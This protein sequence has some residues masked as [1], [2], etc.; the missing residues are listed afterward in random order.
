V[1]RFPRVPVLV[2]ALA[3]LAS[4]SWAQPRR[5]SPGKLSN[6]HKQLE[7]VENC[8]KCHELGKGVSDELCLDCHTAIK[9]RMENKRGL[10]ASEEHRGKSCQK[11]HPEHN[12]REFKL[13]YW[14]EGEKKFD[15][16]QAGYSL[17][18]KHLGH[19]CGDC[20]KP[21]F[22]RDEAVRKD[23]RINLD[24]TRLG[25]STA[26]VACHI[27]EH[28][29][30]LPDDCLKCHTY[31]GWTPARGFTHDSTPYPL[32]GKHKDI[33][34]TKCHPWRDARQTAIADA[35]QKPENRGKQAVYRLTG[36]YPNCT[37]CH[38]DPHRGKH[39]Q[40]CS[41]CHQISGWADLVGGKPYDH[42]LSGYP[43]RG[44]HAGVQ[45]VKCHTSGR[46]TDPLKF[47]HCTDCH[48]DEHRGQFAGRPGGIACE[49]CHTVAGFV[50]SRFTIEQHAATKYPLEGS[51]LAVP[52]NLCH[53]QVA[54]K[55]GTTYAQFTF[56]QR[57]CQ[58]CHRDVHQGRLD[59]WVK[60][61][62][63]EFCH[64]VE[65]WH[66]TSFNHDRTDFRLVGKHRKVPCLD[67]HKEA[68]AGTSEEL[69]WFK[70]KST[71]CS[72]CHEDVHK[73][74]FLR[75][76]LG[77]KETRCDRCHTPKGW[78]GEEL[79]FDHDKDSRFP[80]RG[81]HEKVA[82]EGCHREIVAAEGKNF[83][84]Y[85][86]LDIACASCHSPDAIKRWEEQRGS[87]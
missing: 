23:E 41:E 53:R 2:F 3:L 6:S 26:C 28:G 4:S 22:I 78:R 54:A 46:M 71:A 59:R 57:N 87:Y 65:T 69:V 32:T 58:A 43:L 9:V 50:P 67:C 5:I 86:P 33:A 79:V 70:P 62:G 61:G 66:T 35:V 51:H 31:D 56:P 45:C 47:E 49:Q 29:D 48:M 1:N 25:L 63:C 17:E 10:H 24:K 40:L 76:E 30:Q 52:C 16:S 34:C 55:D 44:R 72:F 74:Q 13:V 80:L 11:C 64:N 68:N 27:D 38:T 7:G 75:A 81:A 36:R 15:H 42:D 37:P 77:E 39:K 18:G 73:G 14:P 83:V 21:I 8:T 60:E 12:G 85:K 84:R 82:C 19:A 20:H